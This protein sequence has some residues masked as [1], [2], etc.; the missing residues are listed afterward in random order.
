V[1]WDKNQIKQVLI[2][3]I[4]NSIE[5]IKKDGK[6]SIKIFNENN[7]VTITFSD[8]GPGISENDLER[9]F[10]LYFTTKAEGTGIG[11][12]II[13]RIVSE[14]NGLITVES[15]EGEGTSFI[16]KLPQR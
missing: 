3:L 4:Q 12:S 6:L 16:I 9:I 15:K 8:T 11:L 10:D 1:N 5:A 7:L 2:N 14:H 13:Q